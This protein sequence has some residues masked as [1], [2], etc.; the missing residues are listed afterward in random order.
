VSPAEASALLAGEPDWRER[1][2]EQCAR[3]PRLPRYLQEDSAYTNVLIEWRRFHLTPGNIPDRYP[4]SL[5]GQIALAKL[6]LYAPRFLH[7]DIPHTQE[8]GFQLDDHMWL[9]I[10]G[11]QWRIREIE[12]KTMLLEKI[13]GEWNEPEQRQINLSTAK[14]DKYVEAAVGMLGARS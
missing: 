7:K 1:F 4:S 12:D 10:A 14:W 11:E 9:S 5:E 6:G 13:F 2:E 8:S 3:W